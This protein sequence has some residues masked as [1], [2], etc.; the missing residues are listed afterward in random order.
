MMIN[1]SQPE[2]QEKLLEPHPQPLLFPK[3]LKR[4]INQI[5][6]QQSP[7]PNIIPE[8]LLEHPQSLLPQPVAAKSLIISLHDLKNTLM[9]IMWM[10]LSGC[11]F[12]FKI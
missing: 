5:K 6:E 4:R 8:R 2:P 12:S 7:L 10:G 1:Q 9:Y 11:I 3:Q